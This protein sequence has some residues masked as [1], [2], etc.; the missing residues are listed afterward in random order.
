MVTG[1]HVVTVAA[2]GKTNGMTAAWVMRVS[3][4]PPMVAVSIGHARYTHELMA[5]TKAFCVNTLSSDQSDYSDH[6]GSNS[7]R[8]ADK[9]KDIPWHAGKTGSPVLENC[10]A[11]LDCRITGSVVAGDHTV[12]VGEVVDA[13]ADSKEPMVF[14]W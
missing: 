7:G 1:V 3:F 12:F 6:F 4:Q 14:R 9:L 2:G 10:A 5:Q 13:G 8:D 11:F